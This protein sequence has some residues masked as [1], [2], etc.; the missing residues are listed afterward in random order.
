M[1]GVWVM[2]GWE[3]V[4]F[5]GMGNVWLGEGN[6]WLG[7]GGRPPYPRPNPR[8]GLCPLEPPRVVPLSLVK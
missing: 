5:W 8:Q 3:R 7:E 2:F 1:F 6:V 4:M